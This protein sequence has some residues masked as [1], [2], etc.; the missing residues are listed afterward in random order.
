M[1]GHDD[2][3]RPTGK[4]GGVEGRQ[5]PASA[6]SSADARQMPPVDGDLPRAFDDDRLLS[7]A[8]DLDE[9]PEL[10]AAAVD[11]PTLAGR[12]TALRADVDRLAAR[13]EA[14]VP[15]PDDDYVDLTDARWARLKEHLESASKAAAHGGRRRPR[16]RLAAVATALLILAVVA[17][18]AAL[19]R[20]PTSVSERGGDT[21]LSAESTADASQAAEDAA[22]AATAAKGR[23]GDDAAT[24]PLV[25]GTAAPADAAAQ[26]DVV[27]LATAGRIRDGRQRFTV[28]RIFK[29]TAPAVMSLDI[30]SRPAARG[31]LHL[32][33]LGS[34]AAQDEAAADTQDD[35]G[36]NAAAA[37]LGLPAATDARL[38]GRPLNVSYTYRGSAV[39]VRRLPAG[40]DP[41]AVTLPEL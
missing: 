33:L 1:S 40:T 6:G 38:P 17:G 32:L 28:V 11:D 22:P 13:I 23:S 4:A 9:D 30:G 37:P 39:E 41:A 35:G 5:V 29:G 16:W 18:V 12:L 21:S 31:R 19:E 36:A 27:V 3:H 20:S 8:L 10:L 26:P 25:G 7:L 34:A 14:S 24:S 2:R 15:A